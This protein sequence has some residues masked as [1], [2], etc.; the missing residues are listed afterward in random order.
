MRICARSK[1]QTRPAV[2]PLLL[3]HARQ[4]RTHPHAA[5]REELFRKSRAAPEFVVMLPGEMFFSA[6]FPEQDASLIEYGA[7][8][9]VFRQPDD[10]GALLR[11]VAHGWQQEVIEENA[12]QI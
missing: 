8:R 3:D 4:V 12:R 1:R 2:K 10:A 6:A 9:K 11:A 7:E 5:Q